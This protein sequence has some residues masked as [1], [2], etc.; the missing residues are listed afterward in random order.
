MAK[1]QQEDAAKKGKQEDMWAA[2]K[3]DTGM[4]PSKSSKVHDLNCVNYSNNSPDLHLIVSVNFMAHKFVGAC[5]A[6]QFIVFE[7]CSSGCLYQ[8]AQEIM[9][10][11]LFNNF[12]EKHHR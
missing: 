11:L 1:Q 7:K 10:S 2:F 4:L 9:V 8:I 3:R 12:Y 5:L 6:V